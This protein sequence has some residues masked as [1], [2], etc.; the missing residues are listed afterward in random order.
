MVA[1]QAQAGKPPSCHTI[2]R[3]AG[4]ISGSLHFAPRGAGQNAQSMNDRRWSLHCFGV[5]GRLMTNR[6][7]RMVPLP[8]EEA[9]YVDGLVASGAY[10]TSPSKIG[11]AHV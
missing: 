4:R 11:R 9:A 6:D 3:G 1:R 7:T 10:A 2:A 5:G 8:A